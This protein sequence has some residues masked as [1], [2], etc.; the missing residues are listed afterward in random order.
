MDIKPYKPLDRKSHPPYVFLAY[1]SSVKRGPLKRLVPIGQTLSEITGPLFADVKLDPGENDL[2]RDDTGKEALGERI[3]VV[4]RV[5]DEDER[6]VP[7]SVIEIWQANAAGRY[8]HP[9]DQH[10]APLDPNFVG[11]GRCVTNDKGE[12]R[13]LTIKPGAYP[14]LNHTNA[15]RPAH[16]HL[17]LFGPS[18]VTRLVTQFFFP[19]D[20]L[21]PLDPILNSIPSKSGR[22]RLIASYA[23]DVTEPEFALGYRFDIVLRGRQ[24]TPFEDPRA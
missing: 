24:A 19:G 22:Q 8:R 3:I 7:N 1:G 12:Y 4:G 18:F 15:W 5:I 20:P 10:N 2:A 17:S 13:F 23:H 16:I 14:W 11:A 21:I 6:P 9:V